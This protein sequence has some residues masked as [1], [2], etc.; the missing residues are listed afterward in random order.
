MEGKLLE[1]LVSKQGMIMD[2]ERVEEISNIG[3]PN[4]RKERQSFLGKIHFVR[5]FVPNFARVVKTLQFLVKKDVSF[6]WSEE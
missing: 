3:L 1:F 2:P 5:R 6:K 4:S